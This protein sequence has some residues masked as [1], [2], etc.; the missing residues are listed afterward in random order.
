[1]EDAFEKQNNVMDELINQMYNYDLYG[2]YKDPKFTNE[3]DYAELLNSNKNFQFDILNTL[4]KEGERLQNTYDYNASIYKDQV[5]TNKRMKNQRDLVQKR[6]D[7]INDE[8]EKN[9]H[10]HKSYRYNYYKYR[11]M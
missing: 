6:Y 10:N 4:N 9:H 5:I 1:M 7:S 11:K 2:R 3:I 8:I